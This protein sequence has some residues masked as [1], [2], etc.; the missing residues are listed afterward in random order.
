M[1]QGTDDRLPGTGAERSSFIQELTLTSIE[2]YQTLPEKSNLSESVG[3][4]QTQVRF[5]SFDDCN[6]AC[7]P[8]L[9]E[10]YTGMNY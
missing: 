10:S 9:V 7:S 5:Q 4:A 1:K 8:R 6:G 3:I 2:T